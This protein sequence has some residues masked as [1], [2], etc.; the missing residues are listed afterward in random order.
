MGFRCR[1]LGR[2][3]HCRDGGVGWRRRKVNWI[4]KGM[5]KCNSTKRLTCYC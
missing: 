3:W 1:E 5:K 4:I 2:L